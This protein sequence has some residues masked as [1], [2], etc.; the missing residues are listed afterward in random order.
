M[1]GKIHEGSAS[2]IGD[3]VFKDARLGQTGDS[4]SPGPVLD[5]QQGSAVEAEHIRCRHPVSGRVRRQKS[6][7]GRDADLPRNP[8]SLQA[9][10]EASEKVATYFGTT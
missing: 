10:T 3:G 2:G 6:G 8:R 5:G 4:L 9:S 7:R 1:R